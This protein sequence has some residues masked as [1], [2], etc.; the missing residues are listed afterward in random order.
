MRPFRKKLFLGLGLL[1]A[2][3]SALP[4][5]TDRE[6]QVLDEPVQRK[7]LADGHSFA[8]L[9]TGK[10]HYELSGPEGGRLIVL[11][12]GVSG[13]MMIWD[14]TVEPLRREGYRVLR[15]DHF[16]RGY[17]ERVDRDYNLDLFVTSLEELLR[18]V[19]ADGSVDLV[20]SSMGA[21]VVSEFALRH[22]ERVNRI[23]LIGPAGFPLEASPVARLV[24]VPGV[25][26]YLMK[27]VGDRT[28]AGHHRRYFHDAA[29]FQD[30]QRRFEAQLEFDGSKAAILSTLRHTPVQAFVDRYRA[31]GR[32]GKEVLLVWGREDQAFPFSHH[33]TALQALP[34]ARFF[35]VEGAGHLPMLERSDVVTPELVSFLGAGR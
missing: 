16:G 3:L 6:H 34:G 22:P 11:V 18:S 19:G 33:E 10:L 12:H 17:S 31:L 27:V 9:S 15:F 25:G 7:L 13:P 8:A 4:H 35:P 23:A 20:G 1:T 24:Q 32:L 2:V 14:R 21:I 30:F 26:D 28:L 29:P 5:V